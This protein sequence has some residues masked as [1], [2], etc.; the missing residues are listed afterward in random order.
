MKLFV[1]GDIHTPIDISKLNM[2]NWPLQA[3]LTRKDI[4][5]AL[6]D[7]GLLW[8]KDW[9]KEELYWAK[10]FTKKKFTMCFIDGNH[11]NFDRINALEET[12]FY[13]G[14]AGVAYADDFGTIYHLKR[15]EVYTF[16]G[17]KVLT[18][19]G[20]TSHDKDS[21]KPYKSWWPE[22]ELS[23]QD[24]ENVINSLEKVD[25]K[26]DFILTHTCPS[27]LQEILTHSYV[28]ERTETLAM[29]D[30]IQN[31]V[32][33]KQWHFGHFHDTR[34][35]LNKYFCHYNWDPY[36]IIGDEE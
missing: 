11:E 33:F 7:Y 17:H 18:I 25:F 23:F 22:E 4:L 12:D 16:D 14:K 31:Q 34:R 15:G 27:N 8:E 5:I 10:W 24:K 1:C 35:M 28:R 26:V 19:G 6:G 21:R 29:F 13:G 9:S 32:E 30:F 36:M 2:K 3:G 20:A